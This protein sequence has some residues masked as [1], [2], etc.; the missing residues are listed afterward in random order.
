MGCTPYL[1]CG[2]NESW[3]SLFKRLLVEKEDGTLAIRVTCCKPTPEPPPSGCDALELTF[4]YIANAATMIGGSVS[5]VSVWNT[6]FFGSPPVDSL[7]TTQFTSVTVVGNTVKLCGGTGITLRAG[8]FSSTALATSLISVVDNADCVVSLECLYVIDPESVSTPFY[9]YLD[10]DEYSCL[11]L[12]TADFP[13]VTTVGG[14]CFAGC[15][16]LTSGF[17]ALTTAGDYC[18]EGCTG[19]VSPDFSALVTAGDYCFAS[20]TGI[21]SIDLSSCTALGTTTGD[22]NVFDGISGNTITLTVPHALMTCNGGSPDG[23]IVYLVANNTVT[24]VY[25]D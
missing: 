13:L 20:C 25:S 4:D 22:D 14:F 11:N 1:A 19:L 18:F 17:S 23:D 10:P 3:Q 15:T 24:I 6:F 12:A 9:Y 2:W 8:L 5:D 21:N 7:F 16:G